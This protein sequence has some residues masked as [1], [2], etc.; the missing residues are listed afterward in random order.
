M[1][2]FNIFSKSRTASVTNH[3]FSVETF[4]CE[5]WQLK[6]AS[7]PEYLITPA[8]YML[9]VYV[10]SLLESNYIVSGLASQPLESLLLI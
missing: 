2:E 4:S 6:R 1:F 10:R 9:A 3:N 5:I 8:Q 7:S